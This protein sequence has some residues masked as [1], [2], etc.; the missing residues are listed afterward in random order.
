MIASFI[1]ILVVDVGGSVLM[2]V[3]SLLCIRLVGR[4]RRL[5]PQNLIWIYLFWV[6]IGLAGFSISRS[7]GHILKQALVLSGHKET[8]ATIR[9]FSGATNTFMFVFVASVTLFFERVWKIYQQ[10]STDKKALQ[11]AHAEL[12]HLNQNLE[13]VVRERTEA[14]IISEKQYR[15][16]FE[17]SRDMIL[18]VDSRGAITDINPAGCRMLGCNGAGEV[19]QGMRFE[20]FFER[21]GDWEQLKA[22][23]LRDG[24]VL[25]SE[26]VL[27]R[28]N[29]EGMHSLI[30][31]SLD[32]DPSGKEPS[33][34]FLV[35]DIQERHMMREQMAQA[36]R[37]ASIGQLSSG[38]AHEI[39]NPLG[40]ILGYTQLMLR[41]EAA[42][43]ERHR[44]LKTV[45]KH[46]RH[47]KSIVEDLLNF[48]RRSEPEK[49]M[50]DIHKTIDEVLG[51]I[52]QH[53][54]SSRIAFE[55]E[56][57]R[58]VPPMMMD[59]KKIKQVLINLLMN[60]RHAVGSAGTIRVATALRPATRQVE[61]E[62][63]DT[64]YGIEEKHLKHI[65]DPFFTTK[66][67]GEGTGLG[68]SVS[69]GI[70]KKHGGEIRVESKP[71]EGSTFTVLLP[72][73]EN[74]SPGIA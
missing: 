66:P 26:I 62:V 2:I 39:N 33:I 23:V 35:R 24:F 44:D 8:W 68:L 47:C 64:G 3:F 19:P 67:T 71:G 30:S 37:L 51:F 20:S 27:R 29:G 16:I 32:S 4:L 40:V 34:H 57:D 1:P 61:I 15:R 43:S 41:N 70:V 54:G 52:R 31:A 46:V 28:A 9:P 14:L 49:E 25:N 55:S 74:R 48:A 56:Y 59:E 5:D 13:A 11:V 42:E 21:Q 10:I 45:E 50:V 7:A 58:Q 6:C 73:T 63:S 12:M 36:D 38:I 17:V 18:V 60:A 72:V 65:F 22:C 53:A 69:Y